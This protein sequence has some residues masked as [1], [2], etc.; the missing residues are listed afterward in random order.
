MFSRLNDVNRNFFADELR[1][2]HSTTDLASTSNYEGKIHEDTH[3]V[4][5]I[6]LT[7]VVYFLGNQKQMLFSLMYTDQEQVL[8]TQQQ[9]QHLW[10]HHHK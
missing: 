2:L 5:D 7:E 9:S 4:H 10:G 3:V 1:I 8:N 6:F